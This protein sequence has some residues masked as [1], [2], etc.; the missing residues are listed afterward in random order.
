MNNA[1]TG[2]DC[3]NYYETVPSNYL[4]TQLWL[5]SDRMGFLLDS[6]TQAKLDAQRDV[7]KNERRQSVDNQPYGRESEI[8]YAAIYPEGHPYHWPVIGNMSDLSAATLDDV[9]HFFQR[10]YAPNNATLAIAGDFVPAQAKRWIAKYFD[11]LP[12]GAPI[13]RP[14]AAPVTLLAEKRL[15][16]QDHVP[17]PRL[18]ITWPSVGEISPD[19]VALYALSSVLTGSRTARLTKVLVYDRKWASSVESYQ[20]KME[21]A[22]TFVLRMTPTPG[23][24]LTELEAAAD[25]IID[26][27]KVEGPT[28]DEVLRATAGSE[29]SFIEGLESNLGKAE[30]LLSGQIYHNDANYFKKQLAMIRMLTPAKVKHVANVYLSHPRVVLSVV[31][32]GRLQDASKADR[33][34]EVK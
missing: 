29:T 26:Q 14:K 5:E 17:V 30:T 28:R 24:T 6:L 3:T 19:Y 15:T 11:G 10:Y 20:E 9:K 2:N 16:Y 8:V 34:T 23:H 31:T 18:T 27:L 13:I 22:G 4:E 1:G 21:N 32:T 33:S 25:S 12:S 7:V